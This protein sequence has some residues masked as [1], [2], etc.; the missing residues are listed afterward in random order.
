[1]MKQNKTFLFILLSL[2]WFNAHVFCAASI[3]KLTNLEGVITV[4]HPLK[5]GIKPKEGELV[6]QGTKIKTSDNA[7]VTVSFDDGSELNIGKNS[8]IRLKKKKKSR[9]DGQIELYRGLMRSK[10]HGM[11]E[12]DTFSIKTPSAVAGV[13]GTVFDTLV[14]RTGGALVQGQSTEGMG[15]SVRT[16]V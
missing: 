6:F 12:K 8:I 15:V 16:A 4:K 10:I 11:T 1:M 5:K 3:G 14:S 13:R 9:P 7:K 2:L